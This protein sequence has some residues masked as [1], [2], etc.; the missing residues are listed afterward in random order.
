MIPSIAPEKPTTK[1]VKGTQ[2]PIALPIL[3][4]RPDRVS[5]IP[6]FF[7]ILDFAADNPDALFH[8]KEKPGIPFFLPISFFS[9]VFP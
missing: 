2:H 3:R 8:E 1:K 5:G 7:D 6:D 9:P 4:C